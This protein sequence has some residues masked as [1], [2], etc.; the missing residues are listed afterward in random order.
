[1]SSVAAVPLEGEL[2]SL[3]LLGILFVISELISS[4]LVVVGLKKSLVAQAGK[5]SSQ[6]PLC[7]L[8]FKALVVWNISQVK[9]N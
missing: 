4:L 5:C 8:D 6:P 9:I 1:M 7:K 3:D 2:S